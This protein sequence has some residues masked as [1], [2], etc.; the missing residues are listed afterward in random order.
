MTPLTQ[1]DKGSEPLSF[2]PE[3]TELPSLPLFLLMVKE[4]DS[5]LTDSKEL[6]LG[7]VQRYSV[8]CFPPAAE[9]RR[10]QSKMGPVSKDPCTASTSRV[11]ID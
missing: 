4:Q 1:G 9:I 8:P 3:V 11:L 6:Q 10:K 7:S 2:M 5:A